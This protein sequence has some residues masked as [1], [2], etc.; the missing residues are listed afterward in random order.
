MAERAWYAIKEIDPV[1]GFQCFEVSKFS[2]GQDFLQKYTLQIGNRLITCDC[3]AGFADKY[4]RHKKTYYQFVA[5]D[6]LGKGWLYN[7]DLNQW[8]EP[9]APSEEEE[10]LPQA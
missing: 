10:P 6:R 7:F 3:P 8:K 1:S 5:Q 9:E 2:Y 4:C